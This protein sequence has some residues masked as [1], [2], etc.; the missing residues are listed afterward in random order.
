MK[1]YEEIMLTMIEYLHMTGEHEGP[2]KDCY[3]WPCDLYLYS[4]DDD[5]EREVKEFV[6][7]E[8]RAEL[9][10]AIAEGPP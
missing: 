5:L 7:S 2:G 6:G 9:C 4:A 8:T 1:R 3:H 10:Q